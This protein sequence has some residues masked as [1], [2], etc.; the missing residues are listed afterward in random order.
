LTKPYYARPRTEFD[1]EDLIPGDIIW[2][3]NPFYLLLTPDDWTRSG[4][5]DEFA[6]ERGSNVVYLGSYLGSGE[7]ID[8]YKREI[9]SIAQVKREMAGWQSVRYVYATARRD[10]KKARVYGAAIKKLF[11]ELI[12][13]SPID[14]WFRINVKRSP[15]KFPKK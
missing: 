1:E 7:V 15:L 10:P 12:G 11:P 9:K 5:S 14:A 2:F 13:V 3:Q 4:L 8:P 6:G